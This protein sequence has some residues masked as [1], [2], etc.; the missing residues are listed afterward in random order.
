MICWCSS[1][2]M[3]RFSLNFTAGHCRFGIERPRQPIHVHTEIVQAAQIDIGGNGAR[4]HHLQQQFAGR[5]NDDAR[6]QRRERLVLG[7]TSASGVDWLPA[8]C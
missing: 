4:L 7:G 5:L 8:W 2:V 1:S 6:Q 3:A